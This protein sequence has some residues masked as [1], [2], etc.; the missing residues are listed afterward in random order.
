MLPGPARIKEKHESPAIKRIL[1]SGARSKETGDADMRKIKHIVDDLKQKIRGGILQTLPERLDVADKLLSRTRESIDLR[2]E[3]ASL[4]QVCIPYCGPYIDYPA[5]CSE[6]LQSLSSCYIQCD[7][8][9][10][11]ITSILFSTFGA[12]RMNQKN[13]K[14]IHKMAM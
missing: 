1:A 2:A 3:R 13:S 4:Q 10:Q 6:F 12:L 14:H 8:Y 11:S 9:S 5:V 7:P